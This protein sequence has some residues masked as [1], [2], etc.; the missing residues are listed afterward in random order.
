MANTLPAGT[1]AARQ[2]SASVLAG[3]VVAA[4]FAVA[5]ARDVAGA[6]RPQAVNRASSSARARHP[7]VRVFQ[8][9]MRRGGHMAACPRGGQI[10]V[11]PL[12]KSDEIERH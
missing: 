12:F 10:I 5:V 3:V 2:E 4:G 7:T 8:R 6:G 1:V 11:L 9:I